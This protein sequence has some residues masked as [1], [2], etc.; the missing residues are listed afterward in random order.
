[1]S[2]QLI[3][4]SVKFILTH[5]EYKGT[6]KI[7]N[8]LKILV[9]SKQIA[10]IEK[11]MIYLDKIGHSYNMLTKEI[12]NYFLLVFNNQGPIYAECTQM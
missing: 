11:E 3:I 10:Y 4:D 12:G 8:D 7:T 2:K 6:V 5:F 1:M 9:N